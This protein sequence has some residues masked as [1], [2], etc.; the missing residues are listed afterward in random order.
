[1]SWVRQIVGQNYK[2]LAKFLFNTTNV[3][4]LY[5]TFSLLSPL[6]YIV[7]NPL[8]GGPQYQLCTGSQEVSSKW[9]QDGGGERGRGVSGNVST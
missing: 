6:R 8:P 1:M 5:E 7:Y 4:R 2:F 3:I 9:T